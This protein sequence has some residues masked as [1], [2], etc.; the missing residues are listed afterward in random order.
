MCI[1]IIP[2]AIGICVAWP[3]VCECSVSLSAELRYE[4]VDYAHC[5]V[6]ALQALEALYIHTQLFEPPTQLLSVAVCGA[7]M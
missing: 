4:V 2:R 1:Y 3:C 7:E 5:C 6:A